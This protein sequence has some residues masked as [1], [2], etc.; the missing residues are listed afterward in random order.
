MI[1]FTL[2]NY[3]IILLALFC[4]HQLILTF[5]INVELNLTTTRSSFSMLTSNF[6]SPEVSNTSVRS[7]FL[8]SFQIISQFRFQVVS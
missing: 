8:Q 4:S 7:D 3:T 1:Y 5:D 6:Q 2:L